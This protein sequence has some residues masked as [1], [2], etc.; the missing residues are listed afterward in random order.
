MPE[1]SICFNTI[2]GHIFSCSKR[3]SYKVCTNC[4]NSFISFSSK[5]N[6]VPTCTDPSLKNRCSGIFLY[7]DI[8]NLPNA[9]LFIDAYIE[10]LISNKGSSAKNKI[11]MNEII[12]QTRK[13][14]Y[15]FIKRELYPGV[16]KT[17]DI[18]FQRKLNALD[19]IRKNKME[20]AY[21]SGRRCLM[22]ICKGYLSLDF[23]CDLCHTTFCQ[24]CEKFKL[25]DHK[26]NSDEVESIEFL[27]TIVQCPY[28][29]SRIERSEGCND[30]TCAFCHKNF[31]YDTKE[32]GGSGS[33]N[34]LIEQKEFQKQGYLKLSSAY[35]DVINPE[36]L[37]ELEQCRP[38][39]VN[40]ELY[41]IKYLGDK[42]ALSKVELVKMI[43]K[44]NVSLDKAKSYDLDLVNLEKL[45][46]SDP[47]EKERILIEI[48]RLLKI[49]ST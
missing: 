8:K 9:N 15:E 36:L 33:S 48:K 37:D 2:E 42:E 23:V 27:K 40:I 46:I 5:E 43:D 30:M 20:E 49:Y 4:L 21:Q 22:S 38:K 19:K 41:L 26:C 29:L 16:Q 1:C 3:C 44:Y 31:H 18:C 12:N 11:Q 10:N 32:I 6:L 47:G 28:C 24:K 14:R 17:I 25:S 39:V 13:E 7:T 35:K 34:V 45:L